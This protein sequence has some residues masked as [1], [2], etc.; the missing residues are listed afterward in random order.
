MRGTTILTSIILSAHKEKNG[1]ILRIRIKDI[2]Q[3][4]FKRGHLNYAAKLSLGNKLNMDIIVKN[5]AYYFLDGQKKVY[6]EKG[7]SI[8]QQGSYYQINLK[9]NFAYVMNQLMNDHA[10]INYSSKAIEL[11]GSVKITQFEQA[12]LMA[13]LNPSPIEKEQQPKL[14]GEEK[15][16]K[17]MSTKVKRQNREEKR[18]K[19]I[20]KLVDKLERFESKQSETTNDKKL[21][22][23]DIYLKSPYA[24]KRCGNCISFN[25]TMCMSHH[26]DVSENHS[27]S[28]FHAFQTFHGGGFS[29]R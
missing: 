16:S 6:S 15:Q 22:K 1:G 24:K 28:R 17:K 19:K 9:L 20:Q 14:A 3:S 27:C 12:R 5:A 7:I 25:G 26:I 2:H 4:E 10:K 23:T 18:K 13:K 11:S 29:P 8:H 21:L